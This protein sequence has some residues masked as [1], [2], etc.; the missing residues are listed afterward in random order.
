MRD[1]KGRFVKGTSGYPQGHSGVR[2]RLN[3]AFMRDLWRAWERH[4][5]A[6]L[7]RMAQKSPHEFVRLV[8][9]LLPPEPVLVEHS[10]DIAAAWGRAIQ[11]LP[12]IG[13]VK[14]RQIA[15]NGNTARIDKSMN[16]K[17]A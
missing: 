8:A 1:A 3:D 5:A 7:E 17:D 6:A 15:I 4:G 11:S 12:A 9:G 13:E 16:D 14:Q 10:H 2:R